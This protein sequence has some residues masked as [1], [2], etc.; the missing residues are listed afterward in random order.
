MSKF[1]FLKSYM[2]AYIYCSIIYN[3]QDMEATQVPINREM[4]KEDT[5]IHPYIHTC[6][7]S[8]GYKEPDMTETTYIHKY[9]QWSITQS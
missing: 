9:I 8:L 3:S 5:F 6:Y 1:I 4:D 7:S 2:Q